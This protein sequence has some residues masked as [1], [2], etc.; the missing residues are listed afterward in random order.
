VW[1]S[2]VAVRGLLPVAPPSNELTSFPL[3]TVIIAIFMGSAVAAIAEEAGFRGYMQLPLERAYGPVT[4]I[5]TT[6]VIFTLGHLNHGPRILPFLPFFLAIA[7]IYGLLT[8]LSGSI[9]P[10]LILHFSGD[11]LTFTL[12]YIASRQGGMP[13]DK[14]SLCA[15][16]AFVALAALS[17]MGFRALAAD[18]LDRLTSR[19]SLAVSHNLS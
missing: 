3:L 4:A 12:R 9:L 1:S 11:V 16:I 17:I 10:S 8:F 7:V 2:F 14:V 5:A 13:T 19:C 6:S 18:S 15:V